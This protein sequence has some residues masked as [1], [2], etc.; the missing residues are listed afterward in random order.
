[1]QS[2]LNVAAILL[3]IPAL[4]LKHRIYAGTTPLQRRL[5]SLAV[6]TALTSAAVVMLFGPWGR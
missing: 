6:A 5:C 4:W 2:F 1:M 3:L